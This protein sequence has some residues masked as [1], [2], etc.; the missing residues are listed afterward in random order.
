MEQAL[1][2][3]PQRTVIADDPA[4]VVLSS[5]AAARDLLLKW[6]LATSSTQKAAITDLR[7]VINESLIAFDPANDECPSLPARA[8]IKLD[9]ADV[10]LALSDKRESRRLPPFTLVDRVMLS[11]ARV[12]R[13]EKFL[14][15][16]P[17]WH[18]VVHGT[19][20]D[21]KFDERDQTDALREKI[22]E[23][24][25]QPLLRGTS[26]LPVLFVI[27]PPG[28]GKSTLV[29]RVAAT[30][31]ETG[32]VVVADAGLNLAGGPNDLRSYTEDLQELAGA[33]RPVLL[34]LDDPLFEESGWID[35]LVHL[36][37]PGFRVAAIAATPDFLYQRYRSQLSKLCCSEFAVA[38]P[39]PQEKQ[40]FAGM[41]GRD[42][43]TFGEDSDDFLVMV[44]EAESG[45]QFPEIMER[46]WQT[47]NG[48][49]SFDHNI[50]FT[51]LPWEVRA[52]WFVCFMHRCYT[53]CPLP[54][55]KAALELSGG[56]GMAINVETALAKL[57]AQSGWSI[58]RHHS[59]P[60]SA[61]NYHGDFVSTAHQKIASAAW[62]QRRMV[63]L[64]P[65]VNRI[66]AQ[67]TV[68]EPL[69]LRNVAVAAGTM[70]KAGLDSQS[71]F[72]RELIEHWQ[73]AADESQRVETRSLCYLAAVLMVN[74]GRKLVAPLED[75]LQA[76]AIGKDGWLAAHGLWFMS[77]D[78]AKSRSFPA[79]IDL[80]S[81]IAN[82][83]FSLAPSRAIQFFQALSSQPE[84]VNGVYQRLFKSLE[85]GVDWEIDSTLFFRL[86]RTAS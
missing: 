65:D 2:R 4:G 40:R 17:E 36:K 26:N 67:S 81:L 44:A 12:Q 46:L 47:L 84:L 32:E 58:F 73:N 38:P 75:T 6:G 59:P 7:C 23:S 66:L 63:W 13:K 25:I 77:S 78:N 83:D 31:V 57:K 55:L 21:V 45:E 80:V 18:H 41:Y 24:L 9:V 28:A 8:P 52:F 43:S 15:E 76:R 33:G 79:E 39:S 50:S 42:I 74:G 49:R 62:D 3:L 27:G 30:L 54:N 34:V 70:A 48:G 16:S 14:F 86:A 11:K 35:L 85:A 37:Q 51:E 60:A 10:R 20:S 68:A 53:L 72:A 5:E 29:R 56:T 22:R 19:D 69:S 82:A 1:I 61:W 64:D 71:V